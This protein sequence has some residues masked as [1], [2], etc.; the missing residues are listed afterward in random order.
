MKFKEVPDHN[1]SL[2]KW[3]SY[4]FNMCKSVATNSSCLSR[5]IGAVMVRDKSIVSTGYNGPPR[6]VMTCDQRWFVD[7]E[8]TKK[9]GF[10]VEKLDQKY[11]DSLQ[12]VCPRYVPEMG[13]S[14]GQ[15]LEW[16]VAGHAERNALINA[17][18]AGIKTKGCKLYMDCGVPCTPCLVEIINAGIEEIIV[19]KYVFYDQSAKYL[20]E[21][22]DLKI[23]LY[24]H[25]CEHKGLIPPSVLKG[26]KGG[27]CSDCG[28]YL[29]VN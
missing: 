11:S 18:R 17:A 1:K 21:Q 2:T 28:M 6:G 15:G 25:F 4:F 22:S 10:D 23:R 16:C 27:F 14:S 24:T 9:A 5:H 26:E 13:F 3:D 29:G 8:M 20:L 12:G 19:T 7:D